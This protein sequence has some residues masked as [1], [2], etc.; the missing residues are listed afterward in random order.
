[1]NKSHYKKLLP[2]LLCWCEGKRWLLCVG[3]SSG[4][5]SVCNDSNQW[6][7]CSSLSLSSRPAE[8]AAPGPV[9]VVLPVFSELLLLI[10][11]MA[12]SCLLH[13]DGE[14]E[15]DH[16]SAVKKTIRHNVNNKCGFVTWLI[17]CHNYWAIPFDINCQTWKLSFVKN[18]EN[19]QTSWKTAWNQGKIAQ[20]G[21]KIKE[22]A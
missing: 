3:D 18:T 1:M 17:S 21:L 11:I 8:G 16:V 15:P 2:L 6:G 9:V 22:S 4:S 10:L 20:I 12:G 13:D 14:T 19:A 7:G 5:V